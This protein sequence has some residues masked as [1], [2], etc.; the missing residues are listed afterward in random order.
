MWTHTWT[1]QWAP[2][3]KGYINLSS[4]SWLIS[5]NGQYTVLRRMSG[6]LFSFSNWGYP[7][8]QKYR[9]P[10]LDRATVLTAL[11][12]WCLRFSLKGHYGCKASVLSMLFVSKRLF[13]FR[14][15]TNY[16]ADS[17]K[18]WE[19]STHAMLQ[20]LCCHSVLVVKKRLASVNKMLVRNCS[21]SHV[22]RYS[23]MGVY[24]ASANPHPNL[25]I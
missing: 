8:T 16:N 24:T 14:M 9:K 4:C 2:R 25:T 3:D 10:D 12:V 7:S 22:P 15:S 18:A 23:L 6:M 5:R 13:M 17:S 1:F 20:D 11:P 21:V 19:I